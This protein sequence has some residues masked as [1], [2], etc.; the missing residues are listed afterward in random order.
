MV[1]GM[2]KISLFK[3]LPEKE[4]LKEFDVK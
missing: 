2:L 4:Q 3:D 1:D